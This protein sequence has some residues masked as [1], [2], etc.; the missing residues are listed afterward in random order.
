MYWVDPATGERHRAE[1]FVAATGVSGLLFATAVPSQRVEHWVEAHCPWYEF[2]GGVPRITVPDNLKSAVTKAGSE[3]VPNP[4]YL[5]MAEHYGTVIL[6]AWIRRPKD[7]A[8]AEGGV[9]VFLRWVIARLRN[10][11]F[12][13]LDE[14]NAAIAECLDLINDRTM[15]RYRQ[16]RRERFE[17]IDRPRSAAVAGALRIRRM[18][19]PGARTARLPRVHPWSLLL[20]PVSPG[21]AAGACSLHSWCHR[22]HQPERSGRLPRLLGGDRREDD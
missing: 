4:S 3:P 7:K 12:H 17:Q 20:R 8:L 19:G 16:S 10:K 6:P 15:R 22:D 11:V 5:A 14:L 2:A 1:I 18:V 21:A 9:L 13:S